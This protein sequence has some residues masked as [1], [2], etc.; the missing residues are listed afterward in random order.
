MESTEEGMVYQK[1]KSLALQDYLSIGYIFLL[2]LG[3]V[4]ETIYYKFLGVNILE[5]SSILDVLI[6]PIAVMSGNLALAVAVI[7]ALFFSHFYLWLTPRYFNYLS[8]KKKYQQGAHKLKLDKYQQMIKNQNGKLLIM[9]VFV[10]SLFIG[11]GVGRGHKTKERIESN[12][13][14]MTHQIH[15]ERGGKQKINML[16]KNS[17]YIFYVGAGMEEVSIAPI[18]GNIRLIQKIRDDLESPSNREKSE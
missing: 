18:Q 7:A 9:A 14:K 1:F 5:Y 12:E 11:L 17:L 15:F 16:G 8:K 10:I 4:H 3:V 6:S 13:I 2:V